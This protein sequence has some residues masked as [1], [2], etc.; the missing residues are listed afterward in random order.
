MLITEL[1]RLEEPELIR[2]AAKQVCED[3]PAVTEAVKRLR[4]QRL[5]NKTDASV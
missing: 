3:K 5:A 4:K 2:A 1:G